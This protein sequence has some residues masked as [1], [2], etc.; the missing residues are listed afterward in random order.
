MI[1][2]RYWEL[3]YIRDYSFEQKRVAVLK[4]HTH[5]KL[6]CV[7]EDLTPTNVIPE[8]GHL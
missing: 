2:K 1:R 4:N 5:T 3:T 8:A 6:F 7:T